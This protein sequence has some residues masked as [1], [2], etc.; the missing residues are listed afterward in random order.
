MNFAILQFSNHFVQ[1]MQI[2]QFIYLNL[3]RILSDIFI[4]KRVYMC[5]CVRACM[6][7]YLYVCINVANSKECYNCHMHNTISRI[8]LPNVAKFQKFLNWKLKNLSLIRDANFTC[9]KFCYI[10]SSIKIQ[11]LK[12][13]HENAFLQAFSFNPAMPGGDKRSYKFKETCREKLQIG[14]N[15]C[16]LLLHPDIKGVNNHKIIL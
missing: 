7:A 12:Q 15:V 2:F 6:R 4:R 13:Y 1:I 16:E 11:I 8:Y 9:L 5:M 3:P 14:L 10:S